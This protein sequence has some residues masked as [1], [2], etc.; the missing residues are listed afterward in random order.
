MNNE[1]TNINNT[2]NT[3]VD[4][5]TNEEVTTEYVDEFGNPIDPSLIDEFGNYIGE[6]TTEY[7][8]EFGN[9]IDPSLIDEFGNYIGD[10][11]NSLNID[12]DQTTIK[13]SLNEAESTTIESASAK[14]MDDKELLQGMVTFDYNNVPITDIVNSIILDAINKGASDIHFDPFDDGIKIRIRIDGELNDYSIV[15]LFVKKNMITRVKIISGMN[16][17]E[18]R[19][20]QDGAIRTE[21]A[22]KTID[23]RVSCLPTNMGEKIVI[24]IM[25]Y[26]MS[27][28]GVEALDF[29]EKNLK[30]VK[31]MLALPNGIILV[32]GATGSGK[33]TTVYSMLQRLNV[34]GTNLITV[35]D[36]I[37]MNIGGVNQVQAVSEI[38][39]TFAT[40]L[41]SILRQ[42]PDV[43][44]IGEIRDDETARIAVRASI[45]G[46]LVLSTIHT[47]NS[48]N[49]IE[50]LTDMSVERYL[51]GTALSGI[52][53]QK[54]AR[55]LCEK[56]K[57]LRPT[58]E[59][60]KEIFKKALDKEIEE[61]YEPVGCPHCSRGYRG[62]IAIQEVLL[63]NQQIQDAITKGVPKSVLRKLVYGENGTETM[64]Q[65]GLEKVLE[66]KTSFDEIIKLIDLEDD[67]GSGSQLGLDDQLEA[68]RMDTVNA[69]AINLGNN[70]ININITPELLNSLNSINNMVK[71]PN[72]TSAIQEVSDSAKETKESKK[73]T[74]EE[75]V[76]EVEAKKDNKK[77]L[78]NVKDEENT[79]DVEI[80]DDTVTPVNITQDDSQYE[81]LENEPEKIEI[82]RDEETLN[83]EESQVIEILEEEKPVITDI[84]K[85]FNNNLNRI[86][87]KKF[88]LKTKEIVEELNR[89]DINNE[90]V[91]KIVKKYIKRIKNTDKLKINEKLELIKLFN[92]VF[93]LNEDIDEIDKLTEKSLETID[94]IEDTA[95]NIDLSE[96]EIDD[97]LGTKENDIVEV[98]I[99]E[100]NDLELKVADDKEIPT[101]KKKKSKKK[102]KEKIKEVSIDDNNNLEL[103]V[104]DEEKEKLKNN[105]RN[106]DKIKKVSIDDTNDLTLD[107]I[108]EEDKNNIKGEKVKKVSINDAN[109]LELKVIE[110]NAN[111]EKVTEIPEITFDD[112]ADFSAIDDSIINSLLNNLGEIKE[113]DE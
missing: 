76:I 25:D 27:A 111:S 18:S 22:D 48:L 92:K 99:N 78:D 13:E 41:R 30:K 54:L 15:P 113:D 20:P 73:E 55:R 58:N 2:T 95:N 82:L 46:H 71:N 14:Q 105:S 44:M 101:P 37:E 88:I 79:N 51:L 98:S 38:G 17:T 43:I 11:T 87:K 77:N 24:R 50:R 28:S 84:I 100:D 33:S 107:V 61:I 89:Y 67:L 1:E 6:P 36:P 12:T 110:D 52:V 40:V 10:T 8:D 4:S 26:S 23:L 34:E 86:G 109:D 59:Y 21:L 70:P 103:K 81:L 39:L 64:L 80:L 83:N 47:N 106:E 69:N 97:I 90:E 93:G 29:N 68:S 5:S 45:T 53:S 91:I 16:I 63:L 74:I 56:C 35:E 112:D 65:D 3:L 72:I 7:V 60:E 19:T 9:P 49:T 32:T 85:Q 42:D 104:I 102:K 62:R 108:A 96:S 66:G 75:P 57:R 94:I 31:K